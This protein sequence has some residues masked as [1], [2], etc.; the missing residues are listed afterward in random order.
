MSSILKV[1]TI[2]NTGGTTGLA[3]D[4]SGRVTQPSMPAWRIGVS[5]NYTVTNGQ[6]AHTAVNFDLTSDT[7]RR[8]FTQNGITVSSGVVTVPVSGIYNVGTT[9][10]MDDINSASSYGVITIGVNGSFAGSQGSYNLKGF[11]GFSPNYQTWTENT[12]FKLD[13]G[14][15]VR[16][17]HYISADSSF[18]ISS[19]SYFS[20]FLIG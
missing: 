18:T 12:I 7:T 3:I 1:D 19:I 14:D 8:F 9:V 15:T 13:A 20:G 11:N 2:Q 4:S 16:V 10:R 17:Y 5:S 6:N